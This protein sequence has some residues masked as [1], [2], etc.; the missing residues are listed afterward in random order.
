[1][2]PSLPE[3]ITFSLVL[4]KA[5]G[6]LTCLR[7]LVRGYEEVRAINHDHISLCTLGNPIVLFWYR[8]L[9]FCVALLV[10]V[11]QLRRT[12]YRALKFF[13]VW[14]WW[15]LTG[16][17]GL[18]SVSS[19]LYILGFRGQRRSVR[20][21]HHSVASAFHILVPM[22]LFIDIVT[23]TVL[24]P[25]LMASPDEDKVAHWRSFMFSFTSYMQHGGNAVMMLGEML[26]NNIPNFDSWS[27]GV[28]GLFNVLFG[29]W[30][31]VAYY[32]FGTAL[33][34]FL[35][36]N[37]P[38]AWAVYMTLFLSG[39]LVSVAFQFLLTRKHRWFVQ[40]NEKEIKVQ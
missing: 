1:M 36:L 30:S 23:W 8:I 20:L 37:N 18:A 19:L 3:G 32:L 12:G 7:F 21:L 4:W 33:Y 25:M 2:Y 26:L 10:G 39:I 9:A 27:H 34:P 15:L 35:D 40:T 14:N 16:F 24:V 6:F 22:A 28:V 38:F 17:F 31:L 5:L 11:S 29:I 13:T